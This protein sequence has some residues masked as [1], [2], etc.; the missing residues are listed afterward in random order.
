MAFADS[1]LVD[2]NL[3]Q[4]LR[5]RPVEYIFK[6]SRAS[7]IIT[8]GRST[9]LGKIGLCRMWSHRGSTQGA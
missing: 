2:D 4:V 7:P 3:S 8:R 9:R 1:D 5:V 6:M